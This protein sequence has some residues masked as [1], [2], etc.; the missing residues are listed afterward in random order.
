MWPPVKS[1]ESPNLRMTDS[2][3]SWKWPNHGSRGNNKPFCHDHVV[4]I[5]LLLL[6][7]MM[8]ERWMEGEGRYG[9]GLE[10]VDVMLMI[11][12]LWNAAVKPAGS[13][14]HHHDQID[15][16]GTKWHWM[17]AIASSYH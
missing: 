11:I 15:M 8:M 12:I 17:K 3:S 6:L 7:M 13:G 14:D 2:Q 1:D 16:N 4:I 10:Y 5:V 9:R